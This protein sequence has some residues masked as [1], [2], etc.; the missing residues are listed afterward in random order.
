M[1]DTP[2]HT[3]SGIVAPGDIVTRLRVLYCAAD[4]LTPCGTCLTC[5]AA[6]EIERLRH[7]S[8]ELYR[9]LQ[10]VRHDRPTAHTDEVWNAVAVA[11]DAWEARREQ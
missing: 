7:L 9:A 5:L 3:D 1:G 4:D 8:D 2:N 11:L 6:D 10:M